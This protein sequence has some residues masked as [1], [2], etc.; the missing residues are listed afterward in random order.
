MTRAMAAA[1][2][3]GRRLV[4][5]DRLIRRVSEGTADGR[6]RPRLDGL[7]TRL[8][9]DIGIARWSGRAGDRYLSRG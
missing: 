8:L 2:R 7:G 1:L 9:D 6:R 4:R 3:R 5:L